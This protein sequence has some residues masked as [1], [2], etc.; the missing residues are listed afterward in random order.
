METNDRPE[1]KKV[2]EFHLA[3]ATAPDG[4]KA[5]HVSTTARLGA[6]TFSFDKFFVEKPKTQKTTSP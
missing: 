5:Y 1:P 4:T 2:L 6:A 3:E